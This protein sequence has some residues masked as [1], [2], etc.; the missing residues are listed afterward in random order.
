MDGRVARWYFAA[1]VNPRC[2]P[3]MIALVAWTGCSRRREPPKD[4]PV[5]A[6]TAVEP[7]EV[8]TLVE[9]ADQRVARKL[10]GDLRGR[11]PF[12]CGATADGAVELALRENIAGTCTNAAGR[13][14]GA[15][16]KEEGFIQRGKT[17]EDENFPASRKVRRF[18]EKDA[19]D[20]CHL[21]IEV[22]SPDVKAKHVFRL[23]IRNG[24]AEGDSIYSDPTIGPTCGHGFKWR[25][26]RTTK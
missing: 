24:I 4:A 12:R 9:T 11:Q 20:G 21:T 14:V 18:E 16:L 7:A 10:A 5:D 17:L 1:D 2:I 25:G 23:V 6:S 19:P 3:I 26:T 8:A 15:V 13:R 22:E